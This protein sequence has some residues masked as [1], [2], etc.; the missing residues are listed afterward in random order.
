MLFGYKK[1]SRLTHPI[2]ETYDPKFFRTAIH[3]HY[4]HLGSTTQLEPLMLEEGEV[5]FVSIL[6]LIPGQDRF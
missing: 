5:S 6:R 4:K 1:E 2:K 3:E